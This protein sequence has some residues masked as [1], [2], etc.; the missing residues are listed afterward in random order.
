[1]AT[2]PDR[3]VVLVK[4]HM[5]EPDWRFS[6]DGQEYSAAQISSK[7]L[8]ALV[9]DARNNTGE[10]VEDVVITVPAYFGNTERET[11]RAAGQIA[12]LNVVDIIN[13]PTAAAFTYG[14]A[15]AD[16]AAEETVLVYDLGGGTFDV[17]VMKVSSGEID[18]RATDG[19]HELG[20][21]DWDQ[22]LMDLIVHKFT[23]DNPDA[24]DPTFDP[25][26]LGDLRLEVEGAKRKLSNTPTAKVRV[27]S[28][29]TAAM[30]EVT[31]EEFEAATS[32]LVEQ[33]ITLTQK[34]IE[35]AKANDVAALDR[36]LLVGGSSLM[37]MIAP[38]VQTATGVQPQLHEPNLAVA[39]GAALWGQKANITATILNKL[40]E[41][42]I[43]ATSETLDAVPIEKLEEATAAAAADSGMT[44]ETVKKV[45]ET[46]AINV[47]SQGFGMKITDPNTGI[48]TVEFMIHRNTSLPIVAEKVFG[49]IVDNQSELHVEV[50]EQATHDE[51][52]AVD[53][54]KPIVDGSIHQIPSGYPAGTPLPTRFEMG[55]DGILVVTVQHPGVAGPVVV[56][57]KVGFGVTEEEVAEQKA[58]MDGLTRAA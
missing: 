27:T 24:D 51:Q 57:Q 20:G 33:T 58:Q 31:R 23:A 32:A 55:N 6:L 43:E 30:V 5:G 45:V 22:S 17:T 18:V 15:K 42:G 47:C 39:K 1:M 46:K 16:S 35:A 40:Q 26:A 19:D 11:T 37:P 10:A 7:V 9:L 50:Y 49:T 28:G 14:F 52:E 36:V 8:E 4:R 25:Y 21:D 53:A 13:E 41:Q 56:Q 2:N 29:A 12:G 34:C 3:V 54:N 44:L 48:E 38:R